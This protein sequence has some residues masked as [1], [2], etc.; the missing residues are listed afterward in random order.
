MTEARCTYTYLT[1]IHNCGWWLVVAVHPSG[2]NEFL[3]AFTNYEDAASY[4]MAQSL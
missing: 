1:A 2:N 3:Q 4:G